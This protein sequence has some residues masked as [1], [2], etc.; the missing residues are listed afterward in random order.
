MIPAHILTSFK[1][2]QD[3]WNILRKCQCHVFESVLTSIFIP[4]TIGTGTGPKGKRWLWDLL[5]KLL[6]NWVVECNFKE[7]KI[8]WKVLL[9]FKNPKVQ[10]KKIFISQYDS[11]WISSI[12]WMSHDSKNRAWVNSQVNHRLCIFITLKS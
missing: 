9:K 10:P 4:G 6:V 5:A 7:P 8:Y 2:R 11:V 1:V 3:D 12:V